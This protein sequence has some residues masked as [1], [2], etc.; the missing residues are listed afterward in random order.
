M[1]TTDK[2][3][4]DLIVYWKEDGILFSSFNSPVVMT[5]DIIKT[6]IDMR[7]SLSDNSKQYWCSDVTKLKSFNKDARDYADK[8]GQE[9]LHAT[10]IIVNSH[11]T[12]FIFNTYMKLKK[13]EI[14]LEAFKSK[15]EA[16]SWLNELKR[17]NEAK[18]EFTA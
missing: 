10:A 15:E 7:H 11:I 4:N 12:R 16:V 17:I 5:I 8:Y 13:A 14:P 3:E 9:L 6:A 2:I 18:H 1:T